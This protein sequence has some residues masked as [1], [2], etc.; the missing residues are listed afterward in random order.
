[1]ELQILCE[2]K[3]GLKIIISTFFQSLGDEYDEADQF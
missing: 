2:D 1:M 3:Y